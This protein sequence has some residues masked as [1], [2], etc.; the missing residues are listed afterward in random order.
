MQIIGS[1]FEFVKTVAIIIIIA[2]FVRFYLVQPFIVEGSSM[3]PTF[4]NGEY[5]LV[6]KISYRVKPPQRGQVVVF[7]PPT[8]PTLNYIKRI[9]GLPGDSIE[10][11][12][13]EIYINGARLLEPYL[14]QG[15]TLVRNPQ[16]ANLKLHLGVKEY[17]V[18]GDNRE[19]SSDS[20]EWG[21]VPLDNII[22]RAWLVVFPIQ[23]FGLVWRPS[24]AQLP[25]LA[26]AATQ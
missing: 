6:D 18:L 11:K 4:Q 15:Q 10:I 3:E 20:R 14:S 8:F 9:I 12:E 16:A 2:F 22:G 21:N 17:F 25:G 7:H 13:G 5:L 1:V 19:H 26:R 23:N 24:Y